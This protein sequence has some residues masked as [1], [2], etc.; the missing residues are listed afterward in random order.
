MAAKPVRAAQE[1]RQI[2]KKCI[3]RTK[4]MFKIDRKIDTKRYTNR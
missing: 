3:R 4:L 2:L 1:N